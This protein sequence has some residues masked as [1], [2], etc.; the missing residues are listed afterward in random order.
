MKAR[1]RLTRLLDADAETV[2]VAVA[3]AASGDECATAACWKL[4]EISK[5]TGGGVL[6]QICVCACV[7]A[8]LISRCK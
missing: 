7:Q 8:E 6:M 4:T 5:V 1:E 3:A 2:A